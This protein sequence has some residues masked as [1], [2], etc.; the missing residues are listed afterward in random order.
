MPIPLAIAP[1]Q[2]NAVPTLATNVNL[3]VTVAT[4]TRANTL[5]EFQTSAEGTTSAAQELM[6]SRVSTVGTTPAGAITA[7]PLNTSYTPGMSGLAS[8]VA[9][10]AAYAAEAAVLTGTLLRW[11]LNANGAL[12]RWVAA[13]GLGIDTLGGGTAAANQLSLYSKSGS[14]STSFHMIFDEL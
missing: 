11:G 9:G 3:C 1:D 2:A 13:P 14:V 4:A 5:R 8:R 10:V 6:I 7:R 12:F